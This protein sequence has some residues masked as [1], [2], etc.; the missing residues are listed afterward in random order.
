MRKPYVLRSL[1]YSLSIAMISGLKAVAEAAIDR[2]IEFTVHAL[3]I[4][5]DYVVTRPLDALQALRF[6][7][8]ARQLM[9]LFEDRWR[10]AKSITDKA[11]T[12]DK[13]GSGQY[14]SQNNPILQ[15]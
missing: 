7:A 2:S 11:L 1:I 12:H 5:I 3:D 9:T 8:M 14:Q 13:F 15:C 4:L 10:G 6:G